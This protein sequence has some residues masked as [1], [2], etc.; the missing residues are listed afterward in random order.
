MLHAFV[1]RVCAPRL[2]SMCF[3]SVFREPCS[4]FL[5]PRYS[6]RAPCSTL[7]CIFAH[8]Y[9]FRDPNVARLFGAPLQHFAWGPWLCKC[10]L[11]ICLN[12]FSNEVFYY[13]DMWSIWLNLVKPAC[14]TKPAYPYSELLGGEKFSELLFQIMRFGA[15]LTIYIPMVYRQFSI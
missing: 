6:F 3:S 7:H 1:I 13:R 9:M 4:A 5:G 12:N 15:I 11:E 2:C 10:I 8:C 14:M